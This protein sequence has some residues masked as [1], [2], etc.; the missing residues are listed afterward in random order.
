MLALDP[1]KM[2]MPKFLM[3]GDTYEEQGEIYLKKTLAPPKFKKVVPAYVESNKI[4]EDEVTTIRTEE[5][6]TTTKLLANEPDSCDEVA[7]KE[8]DPITDYDRAMAI[9]V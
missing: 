6:K 7:G 9:F 5:F 8:K 1:Y 2:T 3:D 4:D